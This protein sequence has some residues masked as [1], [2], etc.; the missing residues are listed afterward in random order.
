[1]LIVSIRA[2]LAANSGW[3]DAPNTQYHI[4]T[5]EGPERFF[6][7]QT[8]S[9]Q[10]RKEKRLQDGTVIGTSGWVDP[11]GYLRLQDYIADTKGYR[12]LKSKMVFVGQ[13]APIQTAVTASKSVPATSGVLVSPAG[14]K[15]FTSRYSTTPAPTP[16]FIRYS[17]NAIETN[18]KPPIVEIRPHGN[19]G[20]H[21]IL[22]NQLSTI[23]P[24]TFSPIDGQ[25]SLG[26]T[27]PSPISSSY[28]PPSSSYLP[29]STY[30]PTTS[31]SP[32]SSYI[33]PTS[34]PSPL[35]STLLPPISDRGVYSPPSSQ[36]SRPNSISDRE[37]SRPPRP[38]DGYTGGP[39]YEHPWAYKAGGSPPS[40]NDYRPYSNNLGDGYTPQYPE[41]DGISVTKNGFRYF[42]PRIYHEEETDN[43]N[44]RTG[45]F[46]YID[47]FG[48]RRVVYFNAGEGKGFVHRKNNRYVG[49]NATPYDPRP[50]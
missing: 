3:N 41:Y 1:M 17:P 34:T 50:Y 19:Y 22:S 42:L 9:G 48:I 44:E 46:G 45:S 28:L 10:Y 26:P 20:S 21:Q 18:T 40:K 15:I 2:T 14:P 11:N 8:T 6:R 38:V 7:Y 23:T 12:I 13:N 32:S 5:D 29:S 30:A 39:N 25:E 43:K 49:F 4:Q 36:Y 27:T 16:S 35:V 31:Y 47:P 33:T 37:Y 24:V